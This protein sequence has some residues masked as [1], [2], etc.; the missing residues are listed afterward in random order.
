MRILEVFGEPIS[1][2]GEE[3]FVINILRNM[4]LTGIQID[5]LTPYF[6]DNPYYQEEVEKRGGRIFCFHLAFTPGRSR[7]NIEKPFRSFL[8]DHHYDVIHVH[9]GSISVLTII[10]ITAYR[11]HIKKIIVHSHCAAEHKTWKYRFVKFISLPIMAICAT[12]Y[13]ACSQIAGD[14]KFSRRIAKKKLII[15]KNGVEL[16]RF[17]YDPMKRKEIRGRLGI[18]EKS[19]VI[20]HVG[21]FSYQ[22]NHPYLIR[23]FAKIQQKISDSKLLL[24]G[25]GENWDMI[26]AQVNSLHLENAV[27]FMGNVPNVCDYLQAMDVFVLPSKFEGLPLVGVEAQAA[28]LPLLVSSNVSKELQITDNVEYIALSADPKE[29]VERICSL[30]HVKRRDNIET[31]RKNGYDVKATAELVRNL[32]TGRI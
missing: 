7:G 5:F 12:D 23:I 10:G 1:N 3:S 20:G 32:Y 9:S 24:I 30:Y 8:K 4:D 16:E 29:W 13:C 11:A 2:G 14:W 21:R 22:K 31:L 27:I 18:A 25:T 15:L 17:K 19:F 26:Q 6:C 28:G